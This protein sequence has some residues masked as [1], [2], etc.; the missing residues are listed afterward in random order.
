MEKDPKKLSSNKKVIP[1]RLSA[2]FPG[3]AEGTSLDEDIDESIIKNK[4][5]PDQV[6]TKDTIRK[7]RTYKEDIAEAVQTQ[8]ASLTS[9]T[10]AEQRRR[11]GIPRSMVEKRS[12][13]FKKIGIV[14]GS[15]IL[16]TLGIGVIGFFA[17]FYEKDGVMIEQDIPS[18][19]FVEEQIEIDVTGK[20]AREILQALGAE[21][22][23]VSL[24]LGQIAHLY[25]TETTKG[26][27]TEITRIISAEELL[28]KIRAQVSEAF[29]R[30][31]DPSFMLGVHVFNQ[32]QPFIIFKSNSYQH[33]FAGLLEWERTIYNDLFLFTG[34]RSDPILG[35]PIDPQTGKEV[36]LREDF[37]DRIIQNI[38]IRALASE[39]GN[40]KFLYAFPDQQTLI[41]TTNENTLTELIT[42]LHSVRVF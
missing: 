7:I 13:D 26:Q 31:L 32:N 24:P 22:T 12:V 14:V 23:N 4:P 30:S 3:E 35:A 1:N 16:I 2:S 6:T 42:R 39:E 29:L 5:R 19:L 40:I 8:K 27:E 25:V 33:S 34:Q 20:N 10:A 15:I 41:I 9:I 17:F 18:F 21:R 11:T 37:E 28:V 36:V 38:D